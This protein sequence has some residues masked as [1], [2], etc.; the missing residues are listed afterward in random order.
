M[1]VPMR[2]GIV[3]RV[4][5]HEDHIQSVM[6]PGASRVCWLVRLLHLGVAAVV[7]VIVLIAMSSSP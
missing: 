3:A 1:L 7:V 2:M 6:T 4:L 5:V